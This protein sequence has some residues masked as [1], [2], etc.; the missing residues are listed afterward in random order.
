MIPVMRS[1]LPKERLHALPP[2]PLD[3]P[4]APRAAGPAR[5]METRQLIAYGL[6]LTLILASILGYR[7]LTR[8]SRGER[9]LERLAER[10]R[11]RRRAER[12]RDEADQPGA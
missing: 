2:F 8:D 4:P 7:L 5:L 9:R 6:I 12:R 1:R 10:G 11:K 3:R